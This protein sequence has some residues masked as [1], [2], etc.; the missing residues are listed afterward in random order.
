MC[1]LREIGDLW[2]AGR[3]R[4][5]NMMREAYLVK[6][7]KHIAEVRRMLGFYKGKMSS[8]LGKGLRIQNVWMN[9]AWRICFKEMVQ[10]GS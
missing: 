6:Y 5:I 2:Y 10:F 9:L 7:L 4:K 3:L 1:V 8:F